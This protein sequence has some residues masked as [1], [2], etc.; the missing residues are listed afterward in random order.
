MYKLL[1]E[2]FQ[3]SAPYSATAAAAKRLVEFRLPRLKQ[4]IVLRVE[5]LNSESDA[6]GSVSLKAAVYDSAD[7]S[8]KVI[9]GTLT[10]DGTTITCHLDAH[11]LVTGDVVFISTHTGAGTGKHTVTRTSADEFTY[12][13]A[14]AAI[15][16]PISFTAGKLNAPTLPTAA[17]SQVTGYDSAGSSVTDIT[18]PTLAQ[19]GPYLFSVKEYMRLIVWSSTVGK[20]PTGILRVSFGEPSLITLPVHVA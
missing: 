14:V 18:V 12:P 9:S 1:T 8:P 5:H 20:C 6:G 2:T 3:L 10:S 16:S 7:G 11:G 17:Y 13:C 15:S 4:D 19:A